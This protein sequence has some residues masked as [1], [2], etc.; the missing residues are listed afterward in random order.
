[1]Q[2]A[3]I[4]ETVPPPAYG[5]TETVIHALT[6]ELVRRGHD[7]TLWATGDSHTS[8][9]LRSVQ[10]VPIRAGGLEQ[11]AMQLSVMHV[12]AALRDAR[13]FDVVHNHSGPP[14]E[15]GMGMS[16]LVEV[17]FLTTLHNPPIQA[18]RHIWEAYSG[19]YNTIS[20]RQAELLPPLPSGIFAGVA[21]NAIDVESFPFRECK[22]AYALFLG[23]L[24]VDKAPHLAIEAA[25]TA[26]VP[27]LLAG[28]ASTPDELEYF[29]KMVRPMLLPGRIEFVGEADASTKRELLAGARALLMPLLWEEPFGLV[30]TEAMACGTPVIA[31]KRGAAPEIVADGETGFL[32]DDPLEMAAALDRATII[33]PRACRHR[34]EEHFSIAA[35][36]DRYE[37]FYETMTEDIMEVGHDRVVA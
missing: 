37:S 35:M 2:L 4:W 16:G 28:K 14:L 36:T 30:M 8:A 15:L 27:L 32:V 34:V 24:C 29:D 22:D 3:P 18:N 31:Y 6:E 9:E 26:G 25:L 33:D 17:P 21:H 1:M 10:P 12:A 13:N 5:G 23:R 19:W 7:V 20:A 11:E